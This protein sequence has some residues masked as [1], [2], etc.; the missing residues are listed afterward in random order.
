MKRYAKIA[1]SIIHRRK[2]ALYDVVSPLLLPFFRGAV[3]SCTSC[4][5]IVVQPTQLERHCTWMCC[6][7]VRFS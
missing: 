6:V 3:Q 5:Q 1:S 2:E 4:T 7:L